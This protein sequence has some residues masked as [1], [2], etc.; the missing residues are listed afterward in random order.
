MP[1]AAAI[2]SLSEFVA[3]MTD[4]QMLGHDLRP[5]F[6][7]RGHAR[8]AR[9]L[10]PGVLRDDF[11]DRVN[12]FN[13]QPK[14]SQ[15]VDLA[16]ETTEQSINNEFRR[17]GSSLLPPDA[18][19]VDIYFLAQH[20]GM[21]TRLLDWTENP[22]AALFFA[23]ASEQDDDGEVI[24]VMP[25]WRMTF[26]HDHPSE[27]ANLPY[28]PVGQRHQLVRETIQYIFEERERPERHLI[29][30]VRPDLRSG[31]MLQQGA[32]FTLH[33]PGCPE[34]NESAGNAKRFRIPRENKEMLKEELRSIGVNWA[35]LF[36]DLDHVSEEI[37]EDCRF[38]KPQEKEEGNRQP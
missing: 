13:I 32:C 36:P 16:I 8:L 26:G 24:A 3:A 9:K 7:F 11:V 20:H 17:K 35:T 31:R 6:W 1:E 14:N 25:D 2:K 5:T 28:P 23:A 4:L 34:I 27:R 12:Q 15:S 19:S 10:L 22:L 38:H 30:P 21:P 18:D 29:I 33:M 37:R